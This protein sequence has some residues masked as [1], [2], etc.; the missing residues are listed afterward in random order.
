MALHCKICEK[1]I[2]AL[3]SGRCRKCRRLVCD[4]C[5]AE[6]AIDS[7]EGMIC[8]ECVEAE[9]HLAAEADVAEDVDSERTKPL[10]SPFSPALP[11]WAWAALAAVFLGIFLALVLLPYTKI[12]KLLSTIE[13][14]GAGQARE[15]GEELAQLGGI[16]A[17]EALIRMT[18]AES[19]QTRLNAVRALGMFPG[20]KARSHLRSLRQEKDLSLEMRISLNEAILEHRRRYGA[21]P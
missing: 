1:E 7:P 6:G 14:G 9:R 3:A 13:Y 20:K 10:R 5:I 8:R 21:I 12:Q 16:R 19:K 2:D 15:A 17:R 18:T 4:E 11:V